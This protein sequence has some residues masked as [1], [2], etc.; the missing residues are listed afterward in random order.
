MFDFAR[1]GLFANVAAFVFSAGLVWIAGVKIS[2]YADSISAQ[3]GMGH[4]LVGLLLLGGVTSLPELAVSVTAA[5]SGNAALAV[6][7]ILGGVA[8]QVA[9]LAVADVVFGR[10]ALT[11][12]VPDPVVILQGALNLVLLSIVPIAILVGDVPVLGVGAWS[13]GILALTLVS[14]RMLARA[15][16]R[17]PWQPG[18]LP[19]G[20]NQQPEETS[21]QRDPLRLVLAKTAAAAA[22]I[23]VAG[24]LISR[25][26]EVIAE[27]TGL[28]SS[29]VGAALVA[30]STSLPEL[31]TVLS[32]VRLGFYT[33]AISDILGT[34][35][36]DIGLLFVVDAVGSGD[37]VLNRVGS[38]SAVGAMLGIMVTALFLVGLAER[39][40]RTIFR[41]GLDS[42]AVLVAYLGGLA[43]LY[44]MRGAT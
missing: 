39:R 33:L 14:F 10:A 43:L 23:L 15:E 25:S 12:V 28:G 16:G 42:A 9:I 2:R 7:N 44:T 11:S 6:N 35:L 40:D 41:M 1:F 8:M 36:F 37:P 31:S 18:N 29:F 3:T 26:A 13:W 32:A 5:Y 17:C 20:M 34:N 27:E 4:A 22:V 30:I 21:V 24:Y 38:F 19:V